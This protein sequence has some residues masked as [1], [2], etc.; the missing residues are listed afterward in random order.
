[1]RVNYR[2]VAICVLISMAINVILFLLYKAT[3][4]LFYNYIIS[5]SIVMKIAL[6]VLAA[7]IVKY[8]SIISKSSNLLWD[9]YIFKRYKRSVANLQAGNVIFILSATAMMAATF[10]LYVNKDFIMI[11]AL[12][13][14]AWFAWAVNAIFMPK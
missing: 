10:V 4:P 13:Y 3:I 7:A 1:M 2:Y 5:L 14:L 9:R 11:I 6:L 12:L 8:F